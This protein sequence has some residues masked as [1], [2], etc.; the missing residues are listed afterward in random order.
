[1]SLRYAE[2]YGDQEYRR[3]PPTPIRFSRAVRHSLLWEDQNRAPNDRYIPKPPRIRISAERRPT[4]LCLIIPER[5]VTAHAT[6][7]HALPIDVT[8]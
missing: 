1:L 4:A 7:H 8:A 6:S 3:Y 2:I 5:L